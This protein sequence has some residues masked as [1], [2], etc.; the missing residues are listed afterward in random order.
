VTQGIDT[1]F[2]V[3]AEVAEHTEHQ[4]ARLKFQY[5]RDAGNRFALAPQVLADFVHGV[6]DPKRLAQP[7]TMEV[8]LERAEIWW[9][10]PE[11]DQVG[12]DALSMRTF[13]VWMRQHRLG[14]KRILD[15][16]L[17]STSARHPAVL[18]TG[19]RRRLRC[20][21]MNCAAIGGLTH[22]QLAV[23]ISDRLSTDAHAL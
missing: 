16:L 23:T 3:A 22:F 18:E 5:F 1:G 21:E 13:F 8:A 9:D 19:V 20:K 6:T 12:S 15:T 11:V 10:S 4:S 7:L 17:A 2:L 14:R